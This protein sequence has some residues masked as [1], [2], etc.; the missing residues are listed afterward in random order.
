[1]TP[2]EGGVA[3]GLFMKII[4]TSNTQKPA[5]APTPSAENTK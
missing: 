1:M 4:F 5:K 3:R 2:R